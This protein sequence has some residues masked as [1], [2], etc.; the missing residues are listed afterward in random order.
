MLCSYRK[1]C[2]H[3]ACTCCPASP[4]LPWH[5]VGQMEPKREG[6]RNPIHCWQPLLFYTQRICL[7]DNADGGVIGGAA[8]GSVR[9]STAVAVASAV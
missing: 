4:C 9:H 7:F 8:S 2:A 3:G 6:Y 1:G 5:L